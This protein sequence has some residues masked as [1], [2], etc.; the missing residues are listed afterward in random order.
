MGTAGLPAKAERD[1]ENRRQ[2]THL[3]TPGQPTATDPAGHLPSAGWGTRPPRLSGTW[4]LSSPL[5]GEV[6]G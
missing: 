1:V 5:V 3:E 4:H 6:A 2:G